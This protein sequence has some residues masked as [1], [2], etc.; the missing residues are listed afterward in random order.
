M[1]LC[2]DVILPGLVIGD[3]KE[4]GPSVTTDPGGGWGE[5]GCY[6]EKASLFSS[7]GI[8]SED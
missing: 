5:G 6:N 4:T 2:L 3:A 7:L 1:C 8:P